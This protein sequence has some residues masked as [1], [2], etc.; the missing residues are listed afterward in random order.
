[1]RFFEK[2]QLDEIYSFERGVRIFFILLLLSGIILLADQN[3]I[4]PNIQAIENEFNIGD[5]EIGFIASAYTIIA[6]VITFAWGYLTDKFS[7]KWLFIFATLLGEIPCFLSGFARNYNELLFLRILTGI[8]IGGIVP[9][10]FSLISDFFTEKQRGRG[11]ALVDAITTLGVLLGM[12]VAGFLGPVH[13]WRLPFVLVSFPNFLIVLLIAVFSK[14]PSRGAGEQEIR[15][16]VISGKKYKG[17]LKLKDYLNLFKIPSNVL[18]FMQGLA[19]SIAWGII[20]YYLIIFYVRYKNFSVQTGT[21]LLIVFGVG[22]VLGK[23]FGGITG[24]KVYLKK[25]KYL[26]LLCSISQF[27]GVL[28]I[29]AVLI[30]PSKLNP[31]LIDLIPPSIFGFLGAFLVSISG[32]NAKVMLMNVNL[33]EHRGAIAPIFHLTDSIGMGIGTLLGGIISSIKGLDFTMKFSSLFWIPCA[34]ILLIAAIF[35]EKDALRVRLA[36][37]NLKKEMEVQH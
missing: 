12:M 15:E 30:W 11:Q 29:Y 3:V 22:T 26:P 8:G 21:I 5:R 35:I 14:E 2:F 27:L 36:M 6:A 13:G 23:F 28:P 24:N 17:R 10:S 25:R 16:L 34:I 33:P 7:R 4:S 1:M 31:K 20:P 32:P 19:G 9:I 18:L 37:G